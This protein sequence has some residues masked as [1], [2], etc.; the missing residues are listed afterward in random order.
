MGNAGDKEAAGGYII[1]D[2]AFADKLV[3]EELK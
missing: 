1:D 3:E 2:D